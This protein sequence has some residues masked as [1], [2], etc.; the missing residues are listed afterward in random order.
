[1][2][3]SAPLLGFDLSSFPAEATWSCIRYVFST[4]FKMTSSD[5]SEH[6]SLHRIAEYH[7]MPF[8]FFTEVS[9]YA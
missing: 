5:F 3:Y 8:K 2:E 7:F 1:M 9:S 4:L 6:V